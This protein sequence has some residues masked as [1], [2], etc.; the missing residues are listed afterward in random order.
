M[1]RDS[2]L[3]RVVLV[4]ERS[5]NCGEP[6]VSVEGGI[7]VSWNG[8]GNDTATYPIVDSISCTHEYLAP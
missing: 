5:P 1:W 7:H 2:R 6:N 8:T 3:K 4:P